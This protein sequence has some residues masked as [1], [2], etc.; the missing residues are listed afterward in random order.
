M[1]LA[2][3]NQI[4]REET[5]GTDFTA[6]HL[7]LDLSVCISAAL[8]ET[9]SKMVSI[10]G[11]LFYVLLVFTLGPPKPGDLRVQPLQRIWVQGCTWVDLNVY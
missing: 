9:C 8:W 5:A 2:R 1:V 10:N 6:H 11:A 4:Q 7:R 3:T